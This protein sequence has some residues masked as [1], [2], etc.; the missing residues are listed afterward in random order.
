[1]VCLF[2]FGDGGRG[3]SI[4]FKPVGMVNF[5]VGNDFSKPIRSH[6]MTLKRTSQ[7]GPTR[8]RH[9]L[10]TSNSRPAKPGNHRRLSIEQ[11]KKVTRCGNCKQKGHWHEECPHPY[12]PK[13]ASSSAD[14]GGSKH[15]S[16]LTAFTY[17]GS[18]SSGSGG[19]LASLL[20]FHELAP[21]AGQNYLTL[22][23]GHGEFF[24]A[25]NMLLFLKVLL[26]PP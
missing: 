11:L 26:D 23:P 19:N 13:G 24:S 16:H 21:S 3:T 7:I 25:K 4:P 9:G 6:W 8:R 18:G 10:K 14:Q 2:F 1:M 17:F 22:P 5:Y 20:C 12:K 15:K